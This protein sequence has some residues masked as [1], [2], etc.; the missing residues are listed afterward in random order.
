MSEKDDQ[1]TS[2][3]VTTNRPA[4]PSD[5]QNRNIMAYKDNKRKVKEHLENHLNITEKHAQ[6]VYGIDREQLHLI[7]TDLL[8]IDGMHIKATPSKEDKSQLMYSYDPHTHVIT[9]KDCANR[10]ACVDFE[11]GDSRP[12]IFMATEQNEEA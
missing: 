9:C 8:Q 11:R 5:T 3:E 4:S 6:L 7:V 12:C 10:D 2:G 1:S